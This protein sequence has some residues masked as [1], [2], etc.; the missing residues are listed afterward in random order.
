MDRKRVKK[1]SDYNDSHGVLLFARL[2]SDLIRIMGGYH[3][4]VMPRENN[5]RKRVLVAIVWG[6]FELPNLITASEDAE[7]IVVAERVTQ[8]HALSIV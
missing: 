1:R 4:I 5:G 2:W 7:A 8:Q 3:L 6:M